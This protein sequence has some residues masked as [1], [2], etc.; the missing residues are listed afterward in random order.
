MS[1]YYNELTQAVQREQP[2]P[3]TLPPPWER[4]LMDD[5]R[6]YYANSESGCTTWWPPDPEPY[7]SKLLAALPP[8]WTMAF[9]EDDATP[10]YVAANGARSWRHP[11]ARALEND[12]LR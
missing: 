4:V 6:C 5:G 8:R 3:L 9:S 10:F 1:H 12:A 7:L 2:V 11:N